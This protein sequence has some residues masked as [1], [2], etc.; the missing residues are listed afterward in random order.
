MRFLA[1]ENF[2]GTA[3]SALSAAGHDV[4][5]ISL[6]APGS[7]DREVLSVAAREGRILLTFDKDLGEL[8]RASTFP[9]TCGV[10]LFRV[11]QPGPR[12][13]GH[14]LADIIQ[15]RDDWAGYFS[16]IEPDRIRM[17]PLSAP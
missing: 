6:V 2:P 3:V 5:W 17:R 10:I 4:S 11:P 8:A 12:D 1:D 14:L 9:A 7:S 15:A 13:A 16:V